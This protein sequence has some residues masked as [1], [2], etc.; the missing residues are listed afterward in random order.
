M[1]QNQQPNKISDFDL[2]TELDSCCKN[3][4]NQLTSAILEAS[5]PQVRQQ[6]IS[7]LQH[8]F[9]QQQQLAQLMMQK[10][11]YRPLPASQ[12]MIQMAK[13]QIEMANAQVGGPFAPGIT[14]GVQ[15]GIPAPLTGTGPI[16]PQG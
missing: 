16:P 11:Y 3:E 4:A 13:D 15:P 1:N 5:N 7:A 8:T 12:Q 9:Q 10:G 6:L 2:M 14:Q